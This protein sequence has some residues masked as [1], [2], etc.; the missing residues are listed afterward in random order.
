MIKQCV[1]GELNRIEERKQARREQKVIDAKNKLKR[2]Q[3]RTEK[4]NS[5]ILS[6]EKSK[7]SPSKSKTFDF[8][9]S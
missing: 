5:A 2:E 3:E 4:E 9:K 6:M 1:V 8:D 7:L